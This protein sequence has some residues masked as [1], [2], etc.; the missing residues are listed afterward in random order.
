MGL[1]SFKNIMPDLP[2]NLPQAFNLFL[3]SVSF[4]TQKKRPGKTEV[5]AGFYFLFEMP[6]GPPSGCFKTGFLRLGLLDP[7][8]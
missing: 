7:V 5:R 2:P 4:G 3:D 6:L 1:W 8:F